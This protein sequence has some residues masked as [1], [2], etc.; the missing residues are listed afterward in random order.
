MITP[1]CKGCEDRFVG[2]HS[3][4]DRYKEYRVKINEGN[5]KM[6][7]DNEVRFR[8]GYQ[9]GERFRWDRAGRG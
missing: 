5:T 4:C 9:A 2:C 3:T 6:K 8:N 7:A 1:P